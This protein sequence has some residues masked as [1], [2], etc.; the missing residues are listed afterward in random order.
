MVVHRQLMEIHLEKG[1]EQLVSVKV[2][3]AITVVPQTEIQPLQVLQP[4]PTAALLAV[5]LMMA[6]T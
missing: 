2:V 3:S 6:A 5:V 1:M 4:L